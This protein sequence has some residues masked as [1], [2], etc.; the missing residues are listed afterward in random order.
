MTNNDRSRFKPVNCCKATCIIDDDNG[1][2]DDDDDDDDADAA[3]DDDDDEGD[4]DGDGGDG[5]GGEDEAQST[6]ALN[7]GE[8]K[9]YSMIVSG[10]ASGMGL[11]ALYNEWKV[12][13][14]CKVLT[15]SS[16]A[17]GMCNRRGLSGK[18]GHVQT[19]YLIVGAADGS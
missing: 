19:R 6:I 2:D 18:T 10:A 9:F 17:R 3:D 14:E 5:D 1:D 12:K 15:D 7:S 13:V 4:G 8:S 16:A 11:Q